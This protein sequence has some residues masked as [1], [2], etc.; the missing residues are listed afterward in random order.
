[1]S[2]NEF[3]YPLSI[4]GIMVTPEDC[5]EMIAIVRKIAESRGVRWFE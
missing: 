5:V 4:D 3:M 1:M 2:Q